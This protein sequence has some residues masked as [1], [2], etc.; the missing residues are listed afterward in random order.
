MV[1]QVEPFPYL[2]KQGTPN[3]GQKTQQLKHC[4]TTNNNNNEDNSLKNHTQNIANFLFADFSKAFDSKHK[5]K[6]QQIFLEYV[7]FFKNPKTNCN[8][9]DHALQGYEGHGLFTWWQHWLL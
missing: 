9:Y 8:C 2:D 5:G 7:F 1:S 6:M 4:V 3:V